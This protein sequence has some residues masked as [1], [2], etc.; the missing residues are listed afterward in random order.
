MS[1]KHKK[2]CRGLNYLNHL[3]LFISPVSGCVSISAFASLI[4]VLVGI[5]SSALGIKI[6]AITARSKKYW[7][8]IT[9]KKKKDDKIVL[10]AKTKLDAI[11]VLISNSL[12]NSYISRDEFFSVNNVLIE[13]NGMKEEIKNPQNV[14]ECTIQKRWKRIV[15][16]KKNNAN[17]NSNVKKN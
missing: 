3:L 9:K 8:I 14:V 15:C 5:V 12:I 13:Q 17:K 10:L 2:V 7:S 1:E 4:G 6:C 11:E 16:C